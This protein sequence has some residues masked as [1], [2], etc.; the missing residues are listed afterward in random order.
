MKKAKI[1]LKL[2]VSKGFEDYVEDEYIEQ[3]LKRVVHRIVSELKWQIEDQ[4]LAQEERFNIDK[5]NAS[6]DCGT[7]KSGTFAG[8]SLRTKSSKSSSRTSNN[9]P[10]MHSST[11]RISGNKMISSNRKKK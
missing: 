8:A 4:N 5:F 7:G 2:E 3:I 1:V 10:S 9:E 11:K 6:V